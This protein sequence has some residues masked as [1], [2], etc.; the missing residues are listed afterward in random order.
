MDRYIVARSAALCQPSL[1][2]GADLNRVCGALRGFANSADERIA[3]Q[4]HIGAL[5]GHTTK[6]N[7]AHARRSWRTHVERYARAAPGAARRHFRRANGKTEP[8]ALS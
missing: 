5:V 3:V 2:R 4:S 6:G 1:E 8:A 7:C